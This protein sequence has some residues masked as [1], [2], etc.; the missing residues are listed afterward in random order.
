MAPKYHSFED[1]PTEVAERFKT[2]IV[3]C[4]ERPC[5]P[6]SD[7]A[8][9]DEIM[10]AGTAYQETFKNPDYTEEQLEKTVDAFTILNTPVKRGFPNQLYQM[11]VK[12]LDPERSKKAYE[13]HAIWYAHEGGDLAKNQAQEFTDKVKAEIDERKEW[14]LKQFHIGYF[15]ASDPFDSNPFDSDSFDSDPL[16][17]EPLEDDFLDSDPFDSNPFDDDSFDS[18]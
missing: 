18:E 3:K 11:I 8:S 9:I 4:E 12:T 2:Q 17:G 10:L 15:L 14:G 16:D 5:P 1:L 13:S 6:I 7:N